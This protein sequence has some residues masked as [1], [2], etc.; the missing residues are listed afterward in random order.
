MRKWWN[1]P[2]ER[3]EY[4]HKNVKDDPRMQALTCPKCGTTTV[5][6]ITRWIKAVSY[7][8]YGGIAAHME[9][10]CGKCWYTDKIY[11]RVYQKVVR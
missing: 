1:R 8:G 2:R 9:V 4:V 5:K 10:V 6:P 3:G 7:M 11:E